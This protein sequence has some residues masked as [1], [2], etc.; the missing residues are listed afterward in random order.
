MDGAVIYLAVGVVA[1]CVVAFLGVE[2]G[3]FGQSYLPSQEIE[4][5]CV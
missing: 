3:W 1:L 2:Y 4:G 5:R